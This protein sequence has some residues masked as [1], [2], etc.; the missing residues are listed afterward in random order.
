MADNV[1]DMDVRSI[2]K[3]DVNDYLEK[4]AHVN[5]IS[6]VNCIREKKKVLQYRYN[7]NMSSD[8]SSHFQAGGSA[9]KAKQNIWNLDV[10]KR[11]LKVEY[12]A[13]GTF[14]S[15]YSRQFQN[16]EGRDVIGAPKASA[17]GMNLDGLHEKR[18]PK[19]SSG[20]DVSAPFIGSDSYQSTFVNYGA[21]PKANIKAQKKFVAGFGNVDG[22]STYADTFNCSGGVDFYRKQAE[23]KKQTL[24][25][26]RQQQRGTLMESSAPFKGES[27]AHREF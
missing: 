24:E 18:G 11:K 8:Y 7:P 27:M 10:E 16:L 6:C 4:D 26:K 25:Y 22:T 17:E 13:P 2:V 9:Q 14:Q 5:C 20:D 3:T 23:I 12:K 21:L 1:R 19:R 15:S